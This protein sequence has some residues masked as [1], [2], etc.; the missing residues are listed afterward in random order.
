MVC[1][2]AFLKDRW[3]WRGLVSVSVYQ[4]HGNQWFF[5]LELCAILSYANELALSF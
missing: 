1:Y 3:L 4:S 5:R 2:V